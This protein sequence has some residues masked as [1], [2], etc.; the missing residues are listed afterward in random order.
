R[1]MTLNGTN[2][3]V[4]TLAGTPGVSGTND[5]FGSSALFSGPAGLAL[6]GAGNIY[7]ADMENH[8]IRR[9]TPVGTNWLVTT[10]AGTPGAYGTNDGVGPQASFYSPSGVCIDNSGTIY[11]A[12]AYNHTIRKIVQQNTNWVVTTFAGIPAVAGTNDGPGA[13]AQFNGPADVAVDTAGNVYVADTFN[14]AIRKISAAGS[15]TTLAG[16]KGVSGTNDGTGTAAR[17]SSPAGV[18]LDGAGNLVVADT[19]NHTIRRIAAN[20]VVS[21][22]A[23]AATMFGF[24]DGTNTTARLFWPHGLCLGAGGAVIV[25]DHGNHAVRMLTQTQAGWSVTTIAGRGE[26]SGTNDG[27]G[28]L[29]RFRQPHGIAITASGELIVADRLNHAIRRVSQAGFVSTIA[30]LP[31]TDGTNDATGSSVRFFQPVAVAADGAGAVYI[32]DYYNHTIRKGTWAGDTLAVSTLAGLPRAPGTND[33]VG[34]AARFNYPRGVAVDS[35]GVLYVAD[36]G[37]HCIRKV[38]PAG[39]VTTFAGTPGVAGTNDGAAGAA[40]F[41]QPCGVVVDALGNV[42]VADGG[43]HAI[44]N[45]SPAGWVTTLAGLPGVAGTNDGMGGQARF[46]RP[47]ALAMDGSGNLFVADMDNCLIR[48]VT[49]DGMVTT[50]GGLPG[51][52]GGAG[53]SLSAQALFAAPA[54]IAVDGQGNLYVADAGNNCIVKGVPSGVAPAPPVLLGFARQGLNFIVWWSTNVVG[55]SLESTTNLP[56]TSWALVPIGPVIVGDKYFV[57]NAITGARCFFRLRKL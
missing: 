34:S 40:R 21:T 48:K 36:E 1:K 26:A 10:I 46:N 7:V 32:A 12:D 49:L 56:A 52:R 4:T 42:F 45:I 43:N 31:G 11:V 19:G 18:C 28:V 9:L 53:D 23:G 27:Q 37:N 57:T 15:V 41:N 55:Y 16:L 20:G 6:D 35:A 50:I 29:A 44:R 3:V 39:A 17:F 8:T 14:H 38:T 5:G 33:G 30:G 25:A 22:I 47:V 24:A 2:W 13:A 54:G 51:A